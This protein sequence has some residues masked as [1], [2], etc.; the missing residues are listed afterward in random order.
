MNLLKNAI[1][2]L[3]D[4]VL[5]MPMTSRVITG[6]LIA[7]ILIGLGLLVK[8]GGT[9]QAEYLF[10]G[11]S[12][13][14]AEVDA[15]ELAFSQA[16]LRG[17]TR[18]GRRVRVPAGNR[19][20]YLAALNQ[21][22]SLPL[23]LRSGLQEAIDKAS[24]FESSDQRK[25]REA[26]AKASD[27]GKKVSAFPE[28]RFA[29]VDYDYGERLGLSRS[30]N[31]SASVFVLPEGND[32][33]SKVRI[34]QI[35]QLIRGAYAGLQSEDVVVID[36][37]DSQYGNSWDEDDPMLR[38]RLEEERSYEQ[39]VRRAL[40]GYGHI[41][42]A[43]HAELDPTMGVERTSL[44]YDN[45]RTTV[46]ESSRRSESESVR[47]GPRGVPGAAPNTV[48]N[49]ATSLDEG[50]QSNRSKEDERESS[51]VVGQQYERSKLAAMQVKRV[52]VSVGIPT[53]YYDKVLRKE[54]LREHP[55]QS[56][57]QMSPPTPQ[58]IQQIKS[59][60][61]NNIKAAVTPL[62]PPVPP[63]EDI[64]PLVNVW[65]YP[66]LPEAESPPEGTSAK[67]LTWLSQSWPTLGLLALAVVAIL[68]ARAAI[69]SGGSEPPR[70]F[71]EGFGLELPTV[72]E[73]EPETDGD[74]SGM[75]I[76]GGSLKDEL[77]QI[78][79]KNPDV[80]AN[81]LRSWITEAA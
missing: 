49:R 76:T 33:L 55:E 16:G 4:A 1:E 57:D 70:E 48:T 41:H 13:T 31:Q 27:L 20:D 34:N 39:K 68:I 11:R 73:S 44:K 80:A 45:E 26:Y 15:V 59:E 65:D 81:V 6:M 18:E 72:D 67:A 63:G 32:P 74:D 77:Y 36:T 12:L 7:T 14:E 28:V 58:M 69:T 37:N 5:A 22:G 52:K 10:G 79:E 43:A 62:L 3:R 29:S 53:S 25:A 2:P 71:A 40:I 50:E 47:T 38:K 75:E 78:V 23:A 24:P 42:V 46:V 51:G 35:K 8:G 21:S 17:W 60:T 66:D 56:I 19:S 61:E 30:R 9:P 64:F 54:F